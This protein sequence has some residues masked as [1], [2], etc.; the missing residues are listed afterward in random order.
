MSRYSFVSKR[1]LLW[2]LPVLLCAVILILRGQS[3]TELSAE[4]S[5]QGT[6][7]G[8]YALDNPREIELPQADGVLIEIADGSISVKEADCPDKRC[9]RMGEISQRGEMIVCLPHALIITLV[10][11]S[12][13]ADVVIG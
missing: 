3:D 10:G 1:D 6:V 7:I 11:D 12:A 8:T 9:V 4:I 2:L 5:V 13:G